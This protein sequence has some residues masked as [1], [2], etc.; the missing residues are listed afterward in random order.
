MLYGKDNQYGSTG[1]FVV[2]G[3]RLVV[4]DIYTLQLHYKIYL[5]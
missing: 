1:A 4:I 3:L 2:A 5:R